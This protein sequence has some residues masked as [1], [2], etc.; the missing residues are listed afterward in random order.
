MTDEEFTA[1]LVACEGRK[2]KQ[3]PSPAERF[4]EVLRFLRYTG[5]KP[6]E[7][8]CLRRDQVDCGNAVI[9][10]E[11][12]KTARTQ[13]T[14]K[15]RIIPLHPEVVWLL[16]TIRQRNEPGPYVFRNHR[17]TPWNRSSLSLRVQRARK[18]A[19]IPDGAKRY[20]IRHSFATRSIINGVDI[21][22]LA[23]LLG[24]SSTRM[25]E[26]YLHL[27]GQRAHLA[28]AMLLA[29]AAGPAE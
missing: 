29:N 7:A 27:A 15:P 13:R 9:A 3:S 23:E 4:R 11:R 14:K 17:G 12:H 8:G 28:A 5:A 16:L 25:T 10:M 22:T 24:H 26:H 20:S 1:L 18:K 2:T 19:G 6:C 21:K